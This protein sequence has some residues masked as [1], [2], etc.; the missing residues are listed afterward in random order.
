MKRK[1]NKIKYMLCVVLIFALL[2]NIEAGSLYCLRLGVE[3][4][5][6]IYE[7]KAIACA[8]ATGKGVQYLCPLGYW[9]ANDINSL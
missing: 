2:I 6:R 4:G 3:I 8:L 5:A 9:R 1:F 7:G